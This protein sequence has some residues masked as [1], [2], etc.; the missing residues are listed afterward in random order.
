MD[1]LSL[2]CRAAVSACGLAIGIW[3]GAPRAFAET[4]DPTYGRIEG[5]V[6]IVPGVGVVAAPRGARFAAEF[7]VRYLESAGLF[8]SYEDGPLLGWGGEPQRVVACGVEV[9]PLFVVRWLEGWELRRALYDLAVDSIGLEVGA[10]FTDP[11]GASFGRNP[12][13]Q[14]GLGFGVPLRGA[15]SGP[16]IG[17]HF[18]IRWSDA[19][20]ELGRASGADDRSL[21]LAV[22]FGYEQMFRAH[23]V[24]VGDRAPE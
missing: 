15:A 14:V 24:D 21:Y 12:G 18:G 16:W 3:L 4:V 10:A 22:V 11:A 7:R 13:L 19:S 9:R 17:A 20:L 8:A 5:D 23:V 1:R 2:R 6:S